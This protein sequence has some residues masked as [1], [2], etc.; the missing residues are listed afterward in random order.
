V[1]DGGVVDNRGL[2][3]LL[4]ALKGALEHMPA[5]NENDPEIWIIMAEASAGSTSYKQDR[6]IGTRFGASEKIANKLI[7]QLRSSV[8]V[9][10]H[11][12]VR[13]FDLRMPEFLRIDG[14]LGTHWMLP[15][16]IK[17]KAPQAKDAQSASEKV[18]LD[19][20][21]VRQLI[22]D[23]HQ[24][25]PGTELAQ[26]YYE[27]D[28]L[29]GVGPEGREKLPTINEWI[30]KSNHQKVWQSMLKANAEIKAGDVQK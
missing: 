14:G 22:K 11:G 2:I 10:Y 15:R 8:K 17:M 1:T 12:T 9:L 13:F 4:L 3:S 24:S 25:V 30:K 26:C 21:A 27:K 19:A 23:L 20:I 5:G 16:T 28:S 6:G 29:F 18:E 7:N